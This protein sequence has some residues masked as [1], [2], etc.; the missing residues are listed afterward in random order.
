M[1]SLFELFVKI[2]G[3]N[4]SFKQSMKESGDSLGQFGQ[5][6]ETASAKIASALGFTALVAGAYAS[7]E[8]FKE[9]SNQI[10]RSTGAT[11]DSLDKL[12]GSMQ[13][14]FA[15]ST[16]SQATIGAALS[17][18]SIKTG[19]TGAAL[20]SLTKSTLN[21]AKV[22]GQEVVPTVQ[23][24]Q[25]LFAEWGIAATSQGFAMDML[26]AG[27]QRAGGTMENFSAQLAATTLTLHGAGF[28]FEESVALISNFTKAGLDADAIVRGLDTTMRKWAAAGKDPRV[29]LEDLIDRMSKATTET[30][31]LALAQG[32]GLGR[33]S[34]VMVQAVKDGA[35][36]LQATI[37]TLEDAK[38]KTDDLAKATTTLGGEMTKVWHGMANLGTT[39]AGPF[40]D[41]LTGILQQTRE[42][43][44]Q[45][46]GLEQ[47]VIDSGLFSV[48]GKGFQ[49]LNNLLNPFAAG[50]YIN[51][52]ATEAPRPGMP[53]PPRGPVP[54]DL[55]YETTTKPTPAPL[56]AFDGSRPSILSADALAVYNEQLRLVSASYAS[57][58]KDTADFNNAIG[59]S[60]EPVDLL[61]IKT[62]LAAESLGHFDQDIPIAGDAL[63]ALAKPIDE[64]N[65][66]MGKLATEINAAAQAALDSSPFGQLAE[67]LKALGITSVDEYQKMA[68]T[69]T[70]AFNKIRDSGLATAD[71]LGI[72]WIKMEEAQ[73]EAAYRAGSMQI[74]EY[75]QRMAVLKGMQDDYDASHT[76]SVQVRTRQEKTLGEDIQQINKQTF[77]SIERGLADSI[78]N[79]K[80][81]GDLWKT[82]WQG[83]AKD[84]LNIMFKTLLDPLEKAIGKVLGGV[85]GGAGSAA[86]GAASSAGGVASAGGGAASSAGSA[87]SGVMGTIGAVS[88]AVGAVSSIIGNFQMAG[89]NKTLDLI[90]N[91]TRYLKIGLVEQGDSLLNDSHVIRNTLTDMMSWNWKIATTYLQ[92]MSINL[93]T[94]A[95]KGGAGGKGSLTFNN[96]NF[97]GSPQQIADAIFTQAALAGYNG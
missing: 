4:S 73:T 39:V 28:S 18:I 63:T 92:G 5:L 56:P 11:G 69:A 30:D 35:F 59:A 16:Q 31:S 68:T 37:K 12:T 82:L 48:I 72:A 70:D 13:T 40:V 53:K 36:A 86:G 6:A 64:I 81:F 91:Y 42:L 77:A 60:I 54:G 8:A 2:S 46:A 1:A 7:A 15:S 94:I 78:V 34:K 49:G 84:L 83:L 79:L 89:M 21:F 3:D 97:T 32:A 24:T 65:K 47:K 27:W 38:G 44:D 95:G 80:G 33:S 52:Y 96:C 57:V 10:Q 75:R 76:G 90:E 85:F 62:A 66:L 25:K 20:E 55:T 26:V 50:N 9:A 22:T 88:A 43:N 93:D 14:L 87:V 23:T 74:E 58:V 67:G 45:F 61:A 71:E 17:E 19:Q 29:M 41:F 51:R